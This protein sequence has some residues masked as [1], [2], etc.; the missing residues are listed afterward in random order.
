ML[1]SA[2]RNGS[3]HFPLFDRLKGLHYLYFMCLTT[4]SFIMTMVHLWMSVSREWSYRM[5]FWL[6][7]IFVLVFY[8]SQTD[9]FILCYLSLYIYVYVCLC[10]H[11]YVSK[12]CVLFYLFKYF[13][14]SLEPTIFLPNIFKFLFQRYF[15]ICVPFSI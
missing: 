14:R 4:V 10:Y 8:S 2:P 12:W 6:C 9:F 15:L 3:R 5:Y 7:S 13:F 11:I 1:I